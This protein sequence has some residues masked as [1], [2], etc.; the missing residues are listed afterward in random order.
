MD[1][2]QL[3]QLI[4]DQA[5]KYGFLEITITNTVIPVD[6][7]TKFNQW[8]ENNYHGEMDYLN[9]NRE[10]R[11]NPA[12]LHLE[13]LSVISVKVPYLQDKVHVHKN[14][15]MNP[16]NAYVSSYALGRDYHKVVKQKLNQLAK[17]INQQII[18]AGLLHQYR[19]F[20]DSAPILEIQLATQGGA[21]WRGKNTLL[22]NK[23]H[24]SM[25]FLGEI[26]TNLLLT[27]DSEESSHCGSCR[28][29]LVACPTNAFVAPYVLDA[30]KCISYLTIENKGAIPIELRPMMGNRIYG[31][32]DC[33][34]VCPWNKFSQLSTEIDFKYRNN[35][36]DS[37][38]L[39]LFKW[40]KEEFTQRMQGSP[41]YRIGYHSWLRNI[42][43]ALGNAP[44]DDEIVLV[45]QARLRENINDIVNE[46][47]LWALQQHS[48]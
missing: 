43:V 34:L 47:I 6:I 45:L 5:Q 8:I 39:E 35:L 22:I 24:G 19:V 37:N 48:V 17:W 41:I 18:A 44:Y 29:C 42:A 23:S 11:F 38:L 7:Q 1:F 46:H 16:H 31:C 36:N 20:S 13:T 33:Q 27:V 15:L 2:T 32:D 14:R 26:F 9:K 30:R 4:K 25:Y 21:G 12:Q 10:L 40:S 28:K 3:T